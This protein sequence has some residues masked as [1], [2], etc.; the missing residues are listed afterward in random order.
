MRYILFLIVFLATSCGPTTPKIEMHESPFL[1]S[2]LG[3]SLSLYA[4]T[5]P[6]LEADIGGN[7]IYEIR[8]YILRAQPYSGWTPLWP[9]GTDAPYRLIHG[10]APIPPHGQIN[11]IWQLWGYYGFDRILISIE[12]VD[13]VEKGQILCNPDFHDCQETVVCLRRVESCKIPEEW[14]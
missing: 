5:S 8:E 7:S 11:E 6:K 3:T 14:R 12:S 13:F 2:V 10:S 4:D 9:Y 1:L